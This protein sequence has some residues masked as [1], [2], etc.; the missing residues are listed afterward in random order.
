MTQIRAHARQGALLLLLA[1]CGPLAACGGDS[2]SADG[3]GGREGRGGGSESGGRPAGPPRQVRLVQAESARLARTV[4]VSGTLA[5]DE[6]ADV[7]AK[8]PGRVAQMYVDLGTPV[9]RGQALARLVPTDYELRVDQAENALEQARA[10]VGLDPGQPETGIDPRQSSVAREAAAELE[11]ARLTRDRMK[12]LLD[13]QLIPRQDFDEAEAAY[14]V[15]DARYQEAVDEARNRRALLDQRRSELEIARKQ[16]SDSVVA[17][18]FDGVVQ[19]RQVGVGDYVA[20]GQVVAVL[21][22]VDPLRL[23]LAIPERESAGVRPG[24]E[25]HL[26]VE[27]EP[28]VHTGRVARISPAISEDN[29]TLTVE[30][31]V[32]NPGGRLRPGAFARAEVVVQL[33]ADAPPSIL[34]PAAAVVTFAGIDKLITVEDGKAVE[35]RVKLGRRGVG[36]SGDRVEVVEGIAPGT[37]VVTRPGNLVS[38]EPVQVVQ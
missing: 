1:A 10:R 13:E 3:K 11:R 27:G 18:P 23:R 32:P 22:K 34:V 35:K 17:A 8:V 19:E 21:V 4:A 14:R 38:G 25:V 20:I 33:G 12:R 16:L 28:V 26:T 31:E 24:Q 7:A 36:Q 30:A 15:A 29:R 2:A 9:R 6:Q 5:A 37:A